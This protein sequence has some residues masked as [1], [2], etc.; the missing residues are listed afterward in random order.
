MQEQK[1]YKG[2]NPSDMAKLLPGYYWM[3]GWNGKGTSVIVYVYFY[4]GARYITDGCEYTI[5]KLS[6]RLEYDAD[7]INFYGPV[8]EPECFK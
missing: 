6:E 3:Q 5:A 4:K 1:L 7:K 8:P 2:D